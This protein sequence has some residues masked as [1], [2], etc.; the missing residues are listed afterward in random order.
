MND[1]LFAASMWATLLLLW[2]KISSWAL[3]IVSGHAQ[4]FPKY[5]MKRMRYSNPG[6]L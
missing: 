5:G 3:H 2:A 1:N 6:F 4:G